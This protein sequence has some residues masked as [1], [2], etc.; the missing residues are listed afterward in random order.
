MINICLIEDLSADVM[1]VREVRCLSDA[2]M[3][4]PPAIFSQN[5]ISRV[6]H[7][8]S[9]SLPDPMAVPTPEVISVLIE[10]FRLTVEVAGGVS[11]SDHFDNVNLV[12]P[13]QL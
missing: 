12:S 9:L 3:E 10:D 11:F 6:Q 13:G 4:F 7:E 8:T 5:V 2:S 1:K